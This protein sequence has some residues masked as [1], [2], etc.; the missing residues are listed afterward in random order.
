MGKASNFVAAGFLTISIT[1]E[2][3]LQT[4]HSQSLVEPVSINA[5]LPDA[6][7]AQPHT[8]S[9]APGNPIQFSQTLVVA[10]VTSSAFQGPQ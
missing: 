1:A 5:P 7:P 3:V 9:E 6:L 8:H 2:G 10:V 4:I